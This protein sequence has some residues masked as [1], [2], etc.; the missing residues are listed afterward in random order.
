MPGVSDQWRMGGGSE[1][2]VALWG[3]RSESN[4]PSLSFS[5]VHV[6]RSGGSSPLLCW[7]EASPSAPLQLFCLHLG[8]SLHPP[9]LHAFP[10][11]GCLSLA[12]PAGPGP[13][14]R[15]S[16]PHASELPWLFCVA[17]APS[18][19][20]PCRPHPFQKLCGG[21]GGR[22]I[23][24]PWGGGGLGELS[25]CFLLLLTNL[26]FLC[27]DFDLSEETVGFY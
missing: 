24:N 3:G 13:P 15:P 20:F 21:L 18:A 8:S 11:P 10:H 16:N 17:C 14:P 2:L 23:M 7:K 12:C 27:L 19:L 26:P 4:I 25:P 1:C 6:C 22:G 5:P 9:A